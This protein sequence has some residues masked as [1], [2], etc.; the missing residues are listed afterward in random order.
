MTQRAKRAEGLRQSDIRR[1]SVECARVDGVNLGQGICDLPLHPAVLAGTAAAIEA[2]HNAYSPLEGAIELRQAIAKKCESFNRFRCDPEREVVVTVGATGAFANVCLSYLD[3]GDEVILFEPYYGYHLNTLKLIGGEPRF[4]T[5]HGREFDIN[6]DELA[7]AFGERTK[8]IVVNTPG[9]PSGKVFT[10]E[11]LLQIG[12]L[13]RRHDVLLVTDEIYEYIVYPGAEHVSPASI[14][15]LREC[16]LTMSGFSK[17][18]SITGW[19]L[20]YVAGPAEL[21]EPLGLVND[22]FYV[23]APTPL[24]HGIAYALEQVEPSYYESLARDYLGKRDFFAAV[25]QEIGFDPWVP[26]G[27]YYMLADFRALSFK[28]DLEAAKTLLEKAH[29]A[30]VPGSAFYRGAPGDR[31]LRFCY[32]KPMEDLEKAAQSLRRAFGGR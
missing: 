29:V 9:N 4:V 7:A 32:A 1:M 11:E 14:D 5:L 8:M 10:R 12:E 15:E 30:T 2:G 23:C 21:V 24:Q 3:P 20:G 17:T 28:D 6:F 22:L 16:T 26:D 13:C 27:A 19:R 31:V 18:F 25:L